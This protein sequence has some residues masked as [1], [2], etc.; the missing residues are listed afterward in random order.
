MTTIGSSNPPVKAD[1]PPVY[2]ELP[3][4][5]AFRRLAESRRRRDR[6]VIREATAELLACGWSV[7]AVEPRKA[8]RAV[9]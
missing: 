7:Y 1:S 4:V 8:G 5:A 9:R 6:S 2:T 3:E